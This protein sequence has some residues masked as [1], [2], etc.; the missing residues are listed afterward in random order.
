MIPCCV[1]SRLY[2]LGGRK[3]AKDT[4]VSAK[5]KRTVASSEDEAHVETGGKAPKSTKK[6][7]VIHEKESRKIQKVNHFHL[8]NNNTHTIHTTTK[9]IYVCPLMVSRYP[10]C[11]P[12][13]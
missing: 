10:Q 8:T 9:Q 6:Q 11:V 3:K 12:L 4:K 13:I 1:Y 7:K 2:L 5:K